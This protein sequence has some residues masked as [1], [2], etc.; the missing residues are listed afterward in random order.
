MRKVSFLPV[1]LVLLF[2]TSAGAFPL[3]PTPP[4]LDM[5]LPRQ[6]LAGY[7]WAL[8]VSD[9]TGDGYA[10]I[11]VGAPSVNSETGRLQ[12]EES[13]STMAGEGA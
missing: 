1:L 9:V 7:G 8:A 4:I 13:T 11:V 10:D 2:F 12:M 6:Q 3:F 5:P